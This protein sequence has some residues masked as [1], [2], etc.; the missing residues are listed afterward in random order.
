MGGGLSDKLKQHLADRNVDVLTPLLGQQ[1]VDLLK[2]LGQEALAPAIIAETIVTSRGAAAVLKD[3]NVIDIL[4][5]NLSDDDAVHLCT[6]L[7]QLTLMPKAALREVDFKRPNYERTLFEWYGVPY[8][9]QREGQAEPSRRA[10]SAW[11]LRAF[12]GPT[13][14]RLRR[15]LY[16]PNSKVLVH[17][18]FGAG[19]LRSVVTAV[20]EA[21]RSEED[22]VNLLWLAPDECL[23]E[24]AATELE[25]VWFQVGLRDLTTYAL[26]GDRKFPPLDGVSNAVVVADIASFVKGMENWTKADLDPAQ[27][28]S[29]FGAATK[30]VVLGDATHVFLEPVRTILQE[31]SR[32]SEYTL[33]GIS[34]DPALSVENSVTIQ[35]LKD[36]YN[37][38]IVE[39]DDE[40]PIAALQRAG[41]TDPIEVYA[42]E[43]PLTDLEGADNPICLPPASAVMLSQHAERNQVLLD[44]LLS[45]ASVEDRIVFYA[46]TPMQARLFASMLWLKGKPAMA[47]TEEMVAS[48]RSIEVTRFNTDQ[49]MQILC[50]H[51]TLVSSEKLDNVTAIVIGKPIVSGAVLFEIVGRLASSRKR[52]EQTLKVYAVRDPVPRYLNLIDN[53][54]RWDK[55]R[56]EDR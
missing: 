48:Q 29:D 4:I 15:E 5:E 19:K 35:A 25:A 10:S 27:I 49:H 54:N 51:G 17:M 3:P 13:Y 2:Y 33:I 47:L 16:R 38:N 55:L 39:I 41:E 18:P 14:R 1:F 44:N 53:L 50:V 52:L 21:L 42:I 43:S 11:K 32:N 7:G 37:G 6:A 20:L 23:A 46:S 40:E 30:Y 34:A 24:E 12:Q 31:M 45:L 8:P 28:L 22:G 26:F 9:E 36:A 56:A